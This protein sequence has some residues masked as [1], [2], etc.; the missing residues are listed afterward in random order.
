M[1]KVIIVDNEELALEFIKRKLNEF[2]EIE[3]VATYTDSKDLI[4]KLQ[5]LEFDVAFLDIEMGEVSGIDLAEQLINFNRDIQIVFVTAYQD[6]AIQ[7]FEL[8]SVDYLLKPVIKG[9]LVK[10]IKRLENKKIHQNLKPREK[11]KREDVFSIDSLGNLSVTFLGSIIKWKTAKV[12]ELFAYLLTHQGSYVDRDILLNQLWPGFDYKKAKVY[13]HT[14]MSY[15]RQLLKEYGYP[16]AITFQDNKYK[17]TLDKFTWD[18]QLLDSIE[19]INP[20]TSPSH[21][22]KIK[23]LQK[24]YK[25]DYLQNEGY[26]W[27]NDRAKM[28]RK[29]YMRI[30]ELLCN[31]YHDHNKQHDCIETLEQLITY[32]PYS[33]TYIRQLM[34]IHIELGNRI[35]AINI[36]QD[37]KKRLDKELGILPDKLT[38]SLYSS[39]LS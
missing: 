23:N 38:L 13:L 25:G 4:E 11:V 32:N 26:L 3:V 39:V 15:L 21:V 14:S 12:K 17:L 34:T 9:R 33:E 1:I 7:A 37:F 35:E 24:A 30:L 28:I 27:V 16:K 18:I 8:N 10:T 5:L 22:E 2:E 29:K 36:Y 31:Y 20:I 19:T 6:Y